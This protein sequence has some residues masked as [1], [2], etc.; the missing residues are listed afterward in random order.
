MKAKLEETNIEFESV[1]K[2]Y[3]SAGEDKANIEERI[4]D[5]VNAIEEQKPL[6]K[7][8]LEVEPETPPQGL[9]QVSYVFIE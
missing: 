2:D 6:L 8:R 5:T 9:S 7:N 4:A 1:L 3:T